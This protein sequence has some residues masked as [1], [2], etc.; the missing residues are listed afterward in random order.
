MRLKTTRVRHIFAD[1]S[2]PEGSPKL[3]F[4]TRLIATQ[5][6][7][8]APVISKSLLFFGREI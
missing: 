1:Y 3:G 8:R 4:D 2:G 7:F 5:K 6:L